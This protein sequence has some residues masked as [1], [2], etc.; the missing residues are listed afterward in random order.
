MKLTFIF[1]KDANGRLRVR[2]KELGKTKPVET[3]D[4]TK[5]YNIVKVFGLWNWTI[6]QKDL[7]KL[8]AAKNGDVIKVDATKGFA[9]YIS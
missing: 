5:K 7:L 8:Q 3:A 6:S 1:F 4:K 9:G 2:I